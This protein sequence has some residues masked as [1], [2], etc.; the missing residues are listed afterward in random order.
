MYSMSRKAFCAIF[1]L[2]LVLTS[3]C[4]GGSDDFVYLGVAGPL[5]AA[6]GTSMRMSAEMAVEEIN[7]AGGIGGRQV[8]LVMM[9]DK[10]DAQV[11]LTIADS[12]RRDSRVVAIVGHLNSGPASRRRP[13][14]TRRRGSTK[15][16]R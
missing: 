4:G 14:T 6:N 12:L 5:S 10:A 16:R 2:A 7:R 9:D 13:S 1:T 11:A 3:A 15:G 8:R